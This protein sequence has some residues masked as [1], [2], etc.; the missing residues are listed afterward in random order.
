MRSCVCAL[1]V[2]GWSAPDWDAEKIAGAE[3]AGQHRGYFSSPGQASGTVLGVDVLQVDTC[4]PGN[5]LL[6]L[7]FWWDDVWWDS[8]CPAPFSVGSHSHCLIL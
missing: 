3:D 5:N 1:E 6:V 7:V 4:N 8:A 2:N